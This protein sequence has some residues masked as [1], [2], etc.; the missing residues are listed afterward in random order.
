MDTLLMIQSMSDELTASIFRAI[1][2]QSQRLGL[3][4]IDCTNHKRVRSAVSKQLEIHG[5]N[6]DGLDTSAIA[7][8][9]AAIDPVVFLA[10]DEAD[11]ED[12]AWMQDHLHCTLA[13]Y[14]S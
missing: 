7:K 11:Y 14:L 2:G 5:I 6:A 4:M 8:H 10:D 3:A 9:V 12:F 1:R 13:M